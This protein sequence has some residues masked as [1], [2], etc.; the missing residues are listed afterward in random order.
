MMIQVEVF[1]VVMPCSIVVGYRSFGGPY[2]FH[3]HYE[4][5][6]EAAWFSET[7]VSYDNTTRLHNPDLDLITVI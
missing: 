5:K 3:L 1:W 7:S 6:M 2:C 4:V